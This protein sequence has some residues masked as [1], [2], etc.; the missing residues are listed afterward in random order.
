MKSGP[1][2]HALSAALASSGKT[3]IRVV[4]LIHSYL[5]I[6]GGAER[7]LGS[8]APLLRR[9]EGVEV[10]V[11]TRREN[12]LAP[13][14]VI[15]G[16]PVYRLPI[17]P[18]KPVASLSFTLSAVPVVRRLAPQVIHTHGLFSTGTTALLCKRLFG[19]PLAAKLLRGTDKYGDLGQLRRKLF[20]LRR[21]RMLAETIE[22]F[23][24]ISGEIDEELAAI[25]VE[26]ARRHFIP[27]GVDTD[28]FA[29][30]SEDE[31]RA[32]RQELGLPDGVL[33]IFTGRLA[34]EKRIDRVI[35]SWPAVRRAHPDAWL[36]LVGIGPEEK[37]L[38]EMAGEGVFFVGRAEDVAPYLKAADLFVLASAAEG[39]S[40]ALLEALA[41][42]LPAVATAVGGTTDLIDHDQSG[43]LFATDDDG[44]GLEEGLLKL[45]GDTDLR[46]S[47][48]EIS[49]QRIVTDYALV[50][51]ARRLRVLYEQLVASDPGAAAGQN[52]E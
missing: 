23:I 48:A 29:P 35:A 21:Q 43:W 40:N 25:G 1:Q 44:S 16:V 13:F 8:L 50:S 22:A 3:P 2:E 32:L 24:A 11:V 15:D 39:L 42:G 5:P 52:P 38:R 28:R 20:G 30:V 26:P 7:Q 45:V 17:P 47:F 31:R 41:S 51:T 4:H 12:G 49:R 27:N 14:E 19:T 10:T 6:V 18:P 9:Q 46:R 34:E 36:V 37:K 33:T